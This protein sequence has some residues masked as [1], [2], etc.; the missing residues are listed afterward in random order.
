M[1]VVFLEWRGVKG[2]H[3]FTPHTVI[4]RIIARDIDSMDNE[5]RA[6]TYNVLPP[7]MTRPGSHAGGTR[8]GSSAN[9]ANGR[10]KRSAKKPS[11]VTRL[12]NSAADYHLPC[13]DNPFRWSRIS[14]Q[15]LARRFRCFHRVIRPRRL[16]RNPFGRQQER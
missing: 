1:R 4:V 15:L 8:R 6:K 2:K 7:T 12:R 11:A 16:L 3:G 14:A 13:L 9:P 10:S 5:G